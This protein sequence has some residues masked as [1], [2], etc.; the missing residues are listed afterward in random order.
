M[1]DFSVSCIEI[2]RQKDASVKAKAKGP[3]SLV[4]ILG[5]CCSIGLIAIS[6]VFEDGMALLAVLLL[7]LLSTLIGLGNYWQLRLQKRPVQGAVVPRGDLVIR[8]PRGAFVVVKCTEEVAR[9]LFFAPETI[10]YLVKHPPIYR[11]IS[12]IGTLM[13]MWG[14]IMLG[15]ARLESQVSF[16]AAYMFMNAAYWIVAALPAKVHWDKSCFKV[17]QQRIDGPSETG[18]RIMSVNKTYTQ[19]LWKV[20]LVTKSIDWIRNNEAAPVTD[21][22]NQWLTEALNYALT[23]DFYVDEKDPTQTVVWRLP[24]WDPQQAF[25][26]ILRDQ[27]RKV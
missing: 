14:V 6:I 27:S 13:L 5:C 19:A 17:N 1:T 20:I 8:Y 22:W 21:A 2:I 3:L 10:E 18:K 24:D 7:S 25:I 11:L 16:A 23:V 12:L 15:N 9:E 4:A 26:D